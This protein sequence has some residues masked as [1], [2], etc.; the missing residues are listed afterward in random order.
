MGGCSGCVKGYTLA[1]H[2]V[3]ILALDG[4]IAF[5]LSTPVEVFGRARLA[6]GRVPYR[7]VICAPTEEV[8]AGAFTLRAPWRLDM[9][10]EAGTIII[11]GLA[12]PLAP[13]PDAVLDALR[14]AAA[15]GARLASICVGAFTLAATGL[16]DGLGAT[17]H[18]NAT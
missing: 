12:D 17:T 14:S 7:V 3:A 11:P 5:D 16:L 1:M 8:N 15:N 4:V 9:L 10:A 13:I 6:D 18:W 2:T